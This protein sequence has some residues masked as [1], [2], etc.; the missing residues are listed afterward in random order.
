M[1]TPRRLRAHCGPDIVVL[2]FG[3]ESEQ[4][5]MTAPNMFIP[6]RLSAQGRVPALIAARADRVFDELLFDSFED[7]DLPMRTVTRLPRR[8]LSDRGGG[9]R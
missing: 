5:I 6:Y 2:L 4:L 8:R 3:V 7:Y 1:H 9:G